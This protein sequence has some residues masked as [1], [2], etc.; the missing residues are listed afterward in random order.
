MGH[1][2]VFEVICSVNEETTSPQM[3]KLF[4]NTAINFIDSSQ[5]RFFL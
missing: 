1:E 2:R 3:I 4:H 5:V